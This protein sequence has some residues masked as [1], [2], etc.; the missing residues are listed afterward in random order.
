MNYI[1]EDNINFYDLLNDDNDSENENYNQD[2][3]NKKNEK[4]VVEKC[5]I[6]NLPLDITSITLSCNH[7]FNYYYI[8]NDIL[9]QKKNNNP[10][11]SG[12][13]KLYHDTIKCP[14][15]RKFMPNLLPPALD[16]KNVKI[17]TF[18]NSPKQFCLKLKCNIDN[19]NKDDILSNIEPCKDDLVYVTPHGYLCLMHYKIIK[20]SMKRKEKKQ[21]KEIL[22]YPIPELIK[23]E[24]K[25][26]LSELKEICKKNYIEDN[27]TKKEIIIRLYNINY[28]LLKIVK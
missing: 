2:N 7:K 26:K 13:D 1:C 3:K 4:D 20:Y 10:Y 25:F 21:K 23:L 8:Y 5:L 22:N 15:C 28:H 12:I 19:H 11:N 24:R 6:S 14:Y 18:I 27:G 17:I 16:I 9:T